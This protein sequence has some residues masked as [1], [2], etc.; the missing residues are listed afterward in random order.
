MELLR[1]PFLQGRLELTGNGTDRV[2][3]GRVLGMV[4]VGRSC[5]VVAMEH[6]GESLLHL[7]VHLKWK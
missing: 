7:V 2:A 5:M 3:L 6:G 1:T 4:R